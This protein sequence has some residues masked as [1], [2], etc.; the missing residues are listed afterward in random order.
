MKQ[1]RSAKS[2]KIWSYI[3]GH[4]PDVGQRRLMA[5]KGRLKKGNHN[6]EKELPAFLIVG[7]YPNGS[8]FRTVFTY[9]MQQ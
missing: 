7:V 2:K 8:V 3:G 4:N 5:K 9:G 6:G 1:V